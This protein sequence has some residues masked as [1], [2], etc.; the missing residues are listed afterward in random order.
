MS[1]E[2]RAALNE[3]AAGWD[4]WRGTC[5]FCGEVVVGTI[6]DCKSHRCKEP[7]SAEAG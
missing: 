5:P 7:P 3:E 1:P 6:E 4:D 2:A